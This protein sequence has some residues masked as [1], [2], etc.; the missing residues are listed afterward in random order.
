MG[1]VVIGVPRR[2]GIEPA[3][4]SVLSL[5]PPN[6]CFYSWNSAEKERSHPP[7]QPYPG[8][9]QAE[10]PAALLLWLCHCPG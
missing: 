1:R 6:L 2:F 3:K 10:S 4:G 8:S 7:V 5:V 9:E